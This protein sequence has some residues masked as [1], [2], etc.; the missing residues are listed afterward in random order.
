MYSGGLKV[1][2]WVVFHHLTRRC[3]PSGEYYLPSTPPSRSPE[4]TST[5]SYR[6]PRPS[7]P[8]A[9]PGRHT[10]SS[11]QASQWNET[12][13][14]DVKHFLFVGRRGRWRD[15]LGVLLVNVVRFVLQ[16]RRTAVS[17]VGISATECECTMENYSP[18]LTGTKTAW[19]SVSLSGATLELSNLL[20]TQ[21]RVVIACS[22]L[23]IRWKWKLE[24]P[25]FHSSLFLLLNP[26][27]ILT[28]VGVHKCRPTVFY[29]Y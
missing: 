4:R 26:K 18:R 19:C 15:G 21:R 27:S 5:R 20:R 8:P 7:S 2:Q 6:A 24:S 16:A 11:T 3:W 25:S 13:P 1:L 10:E 29:Y 22:P 12:S 9:S 14:T 17:A 23:C 28:H